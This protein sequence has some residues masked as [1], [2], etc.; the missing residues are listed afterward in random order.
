MSQLLSIQVGTIREDGLADSKEPLQRHWVSAFYKSQIP[1]PAQ[2]DA[3]GIAG[4]QVA[5]RKHH[6]GH[7]K[8]MLAYAAAHYPTWLAE[9]QPHEFLEPDSEDYGLKAFVHGA[10]GENL[11]IAGQDEHNVCIGDTYLLGDPAQGGVI[12][13]VSQPR[14]PCWKISRRW[15]HRT[16]TKRV[17]QTGR[18][19]WYFRVLQ[20]GQ[21]RPGDPITMASRPH[22]DW[23]VAR[24]NDV[25]MGRLADRF[26]TMELM[27]LPELSDSWKQSLA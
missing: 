19:G 18:T 26:A 6:G 1:G 16:L 25:L 7:D 15:K 22:P 27:G 23:T 2:V 24:A 9:L 5:D 17:G 21:L 12:V 11:T 8:A 10:F 13:Q 3:N 4:D 14:Q 20:G